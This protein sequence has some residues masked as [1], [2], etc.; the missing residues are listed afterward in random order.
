MKKEREKKRE[1]IQKKYATADKDASSTTPNPYYGSL[2]SV[3]DHHAQTYC[4]CVK[5]HS[6][7]VTNYS[8]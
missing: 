6:H 5:T 4:C 7:L 1:K 2:G 3:R 8:I